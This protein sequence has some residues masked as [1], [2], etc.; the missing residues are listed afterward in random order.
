VKASVLVPVWDSFDK[1]SPG[2]GIGAEIA[3]PVAEG[4]R[5][6]GSLDTSSVGLANQTYYLTMARPGVRYDAFFGP[7]AFMSFQVE[8]GWVVATQ[9][10]L[11]IVDNRAT[12]G[13]A[14]SVSFYVGPHLNFRTE[15]RYLEVFGILHAV[16]GSISFDVIG[17]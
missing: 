4:W 9:R 11:N 3:L 14:A 15:L 10:D 8:G 5:V 13:A 1:F 7:T 2:G 6:T 16:M 17:N 12:A